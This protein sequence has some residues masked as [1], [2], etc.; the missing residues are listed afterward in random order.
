MWTAP[1][2]L[3]SIATGL[4]PGDFSVS[5]SE[6]IFSIFSLM[7]AVLIIMSVAKQITIRKPILAILCPNWS[8]RRI[9]TFTF[10][11]IVAVGHRFVAF[12]V[13]ACIAQVRGGR[14]VSVVVDLHRRPK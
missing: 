1:P 13:T 7:Y 10:I 8:C 14:I 6:Q 3:S 11:W 9:T 5:F 4:V 2:K 12:I